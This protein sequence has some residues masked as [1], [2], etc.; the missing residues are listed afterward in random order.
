MVSSGPVVVVDF[1]RQ[2]PILLLVL[3]NVEFLLPLI[4]AVVLVLLAID[5]SSIVVAF[6]AQVDWQ[7][8][9]KSRHRLFSPLLLL[10]LLLLIAFAC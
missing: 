3:S 8:K 5:L 10:L 4:G 7:I 6:D 9:E 1:A 2:P